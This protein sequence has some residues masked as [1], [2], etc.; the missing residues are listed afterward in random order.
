MATEEPVPEA[1]EFPTGMCSGNGDESVLPRNLFWYDGN[2]GSL[3]QSMPQ[4]MGIQSKRIL[5]FTRKTEMVG[6]EVVD[7]TFWGELPLIRK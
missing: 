6:C 3:T 5:D 2:D 7:L 4:S 1:H